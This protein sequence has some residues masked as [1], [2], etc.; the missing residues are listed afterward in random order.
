MEGHRADP[1]V[2]EALERVREQA[3]FFKVFGSYPRYTAT[4]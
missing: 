1:A 3:F 4:A 2:A